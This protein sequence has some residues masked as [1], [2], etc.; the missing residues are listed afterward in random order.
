MSKSLKFFYINT[1]ITL[2][3]ANVSRYSVLLFT[4]EATG[5]Y[6]LTGTVFAISFIPTL[7]LG[8][9]AGVAAD[10]Y[11]RK[12]IVVYSQILIMLSVLLFACF[13][14]TG[15]ELYRNELVLV[16]A[17]LIGVAITFMIPSRFAILGNLVEE[18]DIQKSTAVVQII[19]IG[20]FGLAPFVT[21]LLRS[22]FT[23]RDFFLLTSFAYLV[24]IVFLWPVREEFKTIRGTQRPRIM[25][26]LKFVRKNLEIR[27]LLI[28]GCIALF[29]LGPVQVVL[30]NYAKSRFDL[31]EIERGN[32]VALLG[33]GLFTGGILV[34][35]FHIFKNRNAIVIFSGLVTGLAAQ[36][37][38]LTDSFVAASLLLFLSGV[39]GGLMSTL[40][41]SGLQ[42]LTP[43]EYRGRVMTL[44][45]M[46]GQLVPAFSGFTV[47][48]ISQFRGPVVSF[49]VTGAI[50]IF[51][52]AW[53][54]LRH[55]I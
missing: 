32:F 3:I 36:I 5:S 43:N 24:G 17:I 10:R 31:S 42:H 46:S 30:P 39:T 27:Y 25:D 7:I 26:G 14:K 49:S 20:G 53:G 40:I 29:L 22:F 11:N 8:P 15:N 38:V 16:Y 41:S 19:I 6:S 55:R 9:Y 28:Y 34:R 35:R 52:C 18:K 4:K 21:G 47:A 33:L 50:V 44:Y 12:H 51:A 37:L 54:A 45:S 1:A 23:W 13:F 48:Q 2:L